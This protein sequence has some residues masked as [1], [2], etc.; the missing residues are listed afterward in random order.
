M[1]TPIL[2]ILTLA[3]I[4]SGC[5]SPAPASPSADSLAGQTAYVQDNTLDGQLVQFSSEDGVTLTGTYWKNPSNAKP[6]VVL[7]HQLGRDRHSFDAFAKYLFQE[8]Y[9]VLS[10]DLRGHGDS[11]QKGGKQISF[12]NFTDAEYYFLSTDIWSAKKFLNTQKIMVVGASIGAN[13]A[14]IFASE[15]V[16]SPGVVL[17]SPGAD[18]HG[19]SIAAASKQKRV[20]MLVVASREDA[21]PAQSAQTIFETGPL[22]DKKL[23]LLEN[24]GHGADM[25]LGAPELPSTILDWLNEHSGA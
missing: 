11:T 24:A 2:L 1:R 7:V 10:Y 5:L 13:A 22:I 14:L 18:Y 25:L 4:F 9:S 23:I 16:S 12:V 3:L 21:Y 6:T 15:D 20:A 19:L 17:L 8:G